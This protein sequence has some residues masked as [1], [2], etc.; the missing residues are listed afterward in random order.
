LFGKIEERG[1]RGGFRKYRVQRDSSVC[2]TQ[3]PMI[4]NDKS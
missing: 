1:E 4:E 3:F 2:G